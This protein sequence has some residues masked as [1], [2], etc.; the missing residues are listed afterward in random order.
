MELQS[1]AIC[2][3]TRVAPPRRFP[4]LVAHRYRSPSLVA[5]APLSPY[6]LPA[7]PPNRRQLPP[8]PVLFPEQAVLLIAVGQRCHAF[9][10]I[11]PF[12]ERPFLESAQGVVHRARP[13]HHGAR[14]GRSEE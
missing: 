13:V 2:G 10:L 3:P 7:S 5:A 9:Q 14:F 6:G 4:S 12:A 11:E 1:I 8:P